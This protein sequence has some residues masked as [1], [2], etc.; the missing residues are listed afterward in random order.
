MALEDLV[1][2]ARSTKEV[3]LS[4]TAKA[5][6]GSDDGVLRTTRDA[7]LRGGHGSQRRRRRGVQ[8]GQASS[9]AY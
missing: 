6:A 2:K 3:A 5:K 1:L 4:T 8:Q 9:M 7:S